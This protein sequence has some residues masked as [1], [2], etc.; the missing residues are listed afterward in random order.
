MR[1]E[2]RRVGAVPALLGVWLSLTLVG[3]GASSDNPIGVEVATPSGSYREM[4]VSELEPLTG[5]PDFILV[6]THIPFEGDIP[7]TELS[8]PYDDLGAHLDQ[9]PDRRA[10]II[11]YCKGESMST[12]A[13]ETLVANGYESVYKVDGG[14]VAWEDA[15]LVLEG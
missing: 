7:G 15:G 14:M 13:A 1:S 4:S 2:R 12:I 3:C 9:L 8:L 11:V 6:N 5:D 10:G